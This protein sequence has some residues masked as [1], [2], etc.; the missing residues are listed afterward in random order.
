M[1]IIPPYAHIH[2]SPVWSTG[3]IPAVTVGFVEIHGDGI[4]G[5]QGIGVST[6]KAAAVAVAT[7]G[8]VMVEHIPNGLIF[9]KGTKSLIVATATPET[10]TEFFG[11]TQSV[12][13]AIP[14][15]HFKQAPQTTTDILHHT[16]ELPCTYYE[17]LP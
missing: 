11:R 7:A 17:L 16:T 1:L 5:M 15:E 9:S 6:P 12:D 3:A 8:F 10:N 13:G 4:T 14:K 2:I